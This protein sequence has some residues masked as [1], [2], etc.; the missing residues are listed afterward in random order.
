MT[1]LTQTPNVHV[2]YAVA[3]KKTAWMENKHKK[4]AIYYAEFKRKKMRNRLTET[5]S[6]RYR[7]P[8]TLSLQGQHPYC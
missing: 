5:S 3:T 8:W 2:E 6:S 7:K 4:D 1:E